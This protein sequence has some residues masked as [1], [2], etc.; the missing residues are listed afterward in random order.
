VTKPETVT[1][2][3]G[4]NGLS[5]AVLRAKYL[6]YCSARVA[7]VLLGLSPDE[8]YLLAQDAARDAG[9]GDVDPLSYDEMVRLATQRLSD[10]LVLPPFEEWVEA[11]RAN[12]SAIERELLGLWR[13]GLEEGG[14]PDS[15]SGG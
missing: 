4:H 6:D 10:R 8:M 3:P 2:D 11:Y 14:G 5:E 9:R 7:D 1:P 13:S 15:G 12:P